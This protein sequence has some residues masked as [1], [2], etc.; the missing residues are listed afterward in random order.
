MTDGVTEAIGP[1][2]RPLGVSGLVELIQSCVALPESERLKRIIG[3]LN[4]AGRPAPTDDVT[5]LVTE[6]QMS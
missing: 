3:A 2:G 1:H 4:N 5:L 6:A